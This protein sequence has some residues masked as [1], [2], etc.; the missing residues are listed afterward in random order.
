[1]L[2]V[3]LNSSITRAIFNLLD[4]RV[5]ITTVGSSILPTVTLTGLAL[6]PSHWQKGEGPA[7][8]WPERLRAHGKRTYRFLLWAD[9]LFPPTGQWLLSM[10]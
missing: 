4:S 1:M 5:S 9:Q 3:V 2:R 6:N 7:S 10:G 8:G